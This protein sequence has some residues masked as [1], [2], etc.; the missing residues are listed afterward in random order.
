MDFT[1]PILLFPA[2]VHIG[3]KNP[4]NTRIL[5]IINGVH[6]IVIVIILQYIK[7]IDL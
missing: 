1:Q 2:I 3:K 6:L 5:Q 4:Q 7:I